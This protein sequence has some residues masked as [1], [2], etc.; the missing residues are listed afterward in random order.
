[1]PWLTCLP[2]QN[3][4]DSD[5]LEMQSSKRKRWK[6]E[7]VKWGEVGVKIKEPDRKHHALDEHGMMNH[8]AIPR[9]KKNLGK[10][11]E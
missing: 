3:K 10:K 2:A 6:K 1:M 8:S 7:Q 5:G 11:K 9:G 4:Q